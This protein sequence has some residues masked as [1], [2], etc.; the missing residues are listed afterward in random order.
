MH[1]LRYATKRRV[2][3]VAEKPSETRSNGSTTLDL[4]DDRLIFRFH[5]FDLRFD[6]AI[7][8]SGYPG[9]VGLYRAPA[10]FSGKDAFCLLLG[11]DRERG[12]GF[13][14]TEETASGRFQ[15][16]VSY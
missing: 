6:R 12:R 8:L 16:C 9:L 15:F 2:S 11:C 7:T 4:Q 14:K 5:R 1:A 3:D 10:D 13:V